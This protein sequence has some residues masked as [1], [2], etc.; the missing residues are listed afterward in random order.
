[1][2]ASAPNSPCIS[3]CNI[4][5][6]GWCQGCY[7]TIDEIAGWVRLGAAGQWAVLRACAA[8]RA[9]AEPGRAA[10]RT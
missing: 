5:P 4:G 9:A 3:V 8:R 7:R 6:N 1:M 10:D 2:T